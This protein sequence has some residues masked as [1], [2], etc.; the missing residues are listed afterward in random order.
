ML[1]G[2][3]GSR[4]VLSP[5]QMQKWRLD[6][7]VGA[8]SRN[9]AI[10]TQFRDGGGDGYDRLAAGRDYCAYRTNALSHYPTPGCAEEPQGHCN[11]SHAKVVFCMQGSGYSGSVHTKRDSRKTANTV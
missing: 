2:A 9:T 10:I 4:N 6:R 8:E 11:H 5:S 7:Y 1:S 3:P